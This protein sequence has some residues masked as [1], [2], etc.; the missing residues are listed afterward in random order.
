MLAL[1]TAPYWLTAGILAAFSSCGDGYVVHGPVAQ[2]R[3]HGDPAPSSG[4]DW[5]FDE[6]QVRTY[7]LELGAAEWADLQARALEEQYVAAS[8][9]VDGELVGPVGL[10][11]KGNAGTLARCARPGA[12]ICSKVSMKIKLDEVDPAQRWHG[13]KRLNFNSA[14]S[15]PTYLHE[16]LGYH[17]FREMGVPTPRSGYARLVV[18]GEDRGLYSL[19]EGIDGRFTDDRFERGDGNL[20]KEQWP[21]TS[22]ART[23]SDGLETNEDA[24]YPHAML[25]FKAALAA[26]KSEEL[27]DVV[28]RYM[29]IDQL[30]AYLVVDRAIANW[31]GI[32]AFYC[33]GN[34]CRN[35]NYFFYQH[36]DEARFSLIPW[37]LDNTF[38]V[39]HSFEYV[40]SA[41]TVPEDCAARYP[42][43]GNMT[44][45]APGC[46]PLLQ[47]A[48]RTDRSR[49]QAQQTRLLEGPFSPK[50]LDPW[51]DARVA[52]LTP[53]VAADTRGPSRSEFLG[54]VEGLRR[55]LHLFRERLRAERDGE[56]TALSRL[57]VSALNDFEAAT[58]FGVRFGNPARAGLG[59]SSEI[60]LRSS[61]ALA[62]RRA[63]ELGFE[64]ADSGEPWTQWARF[65]L[66]FNSPNPTDLTGKSLLRFVLRA[67]APRRVRISL[68]SSNY[69]VVERDET[70]GWDVDVDGTRQL[71]ELPLASASLPAGTRLT[72]Q[73]GDILPYATAIIIEPKVQGRNADGLLGRAKRDA[74]HL[75]LDELQFLP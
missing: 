18:N 40:P 43:L 13:L 56:S 27:P 49:H 38:R 12:L 14:L 74:G 31:D 64:L 24:P 35:H 28:A 3:P 11:F 60:R 48:A 36:E 19:V 1:R 58:P 33:F 53:L 4:L 55:D 67:D 71:I 25:D 2:E 23:L 65:T 50:T 70:F 61:D 34:G 30:L 21:T 10:R 8:L 37:D 72:D 16:R 51:L 52:Q 44:A 15:D 6:E 20:Y 22:S 41:L 62:G 57:E 32:T 17:L 45:L 69:S 7:E 9:S 59:S 47:G 29:D 75:Q 26:A 73:L 42:T 46:D 66:S 39:S 5:V 63:L 54:A 68:D